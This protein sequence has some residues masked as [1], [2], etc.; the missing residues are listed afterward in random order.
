QEIVSAKSGELRNPGTIR[1]D[2]TEV[3]AAVIAAA[4]RLPHPQDGKPSTGDAEL[5]NGGRAVLLLT[6]VATPEAA[7]LNEV[8]QRRLR[9]ASAGAQ[10]GA[11]MSTIEQEVGIE[12]RER[13]QDVPAE[14]LDES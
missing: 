6:A 2:N 10:F 7:T 8:Q 4:F 14:A 5:A 9:D 1:R 13:P 11:Y 3:E 12:L